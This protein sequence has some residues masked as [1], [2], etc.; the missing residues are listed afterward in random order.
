MCS[1]T[2]TSSVA[3]FTTLCNNNSW[4]F[5]KW[6]A[7]SDSAEAQRFSRAYMGSGFAKSGGGCP[8]GGL[9]VI[10]DDEL[11]EEQFKFAHCYVCSGYSM[12]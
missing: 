12:P 3:C 6:Q 5:G 7:A 11:A 2:M 8:V 1:N 4:I 10:I 9:Q